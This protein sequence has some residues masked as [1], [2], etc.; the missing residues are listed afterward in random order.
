MQTLLVYLSD[1]MAVYCFLLRSCSLLPM[2]YCRIV[3]YCEDRSCRDDLVR[4]VHSRRIVLIVDDEEQLVKNWA[5]LV[6]L[7]S[8]KG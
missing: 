7:A 3:D 4:N 8:H 2:A 6:P 1:S 5:Y